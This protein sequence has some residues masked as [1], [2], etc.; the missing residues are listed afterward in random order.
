MPSSR[1]HHLR[2]PSEN[3]LGFEW[4][5]LE[6][7]DGIF[8]SEAWE[9]MNFDSKARLS[10]EMAHILQQLSSLRF[11]EIGNLYFSEVQNQVSDRIL[12][13]HG[14]EIKDGTKAHD[15]TAFYPNNEDDNDIETEKSVLSSA[16]TANVDRGIGTEFV[17]GRIVSPWFFRD[18]RV[19][20]PADRGPFSSS[21]ELMM[22]KT[23]IQ[24]ERIKVL[25]P[26]PTDEYHSQ[27]NEELAE[28]Q[29]EILKT[30]HDSKELIPYY[31]PALDNS[32]GINTLYHSDISIRNIIVDPKTYRITGIVDWE[33]VSICPSWETFAYPH[34]L[35]GIEVGKPPSLGDPAVDEDALTEIRKDWERVLLRK[36]YLESM[37]DAG[38]GLSGIPLAHETMSDNEIERKQRF[39]TF[40]Y[41]IELRWEA[42]RHWMPDLRSLVGLE[43]GRVGEDD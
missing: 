10:R 23:Q 8:L 40:L 18:K 28:D 24:I 35:K 39:A 36:V 22:A 34:F 26:L 5:L 6:K 21:Y 15:S 19:L 17:V 16:S 14:A 20:L 12:S 29:D 42:A 31:F 25:S 38:K 7:I 9:G 33:S 30:C 1:D 32:K 3:P 11:R 41:E 27:I 43:S 13:S 4:I 2:S 37:T